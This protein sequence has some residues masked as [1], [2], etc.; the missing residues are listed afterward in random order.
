MNRL[1]FVFAMSLAPTFQGCDG[2]SYPLGR[3]VTPAGAGNGG[4]AG[5]AAAGTGSGGADGG[6]GGG[7]AS[8]AGAG[9]D[10]GAS[11]TDPSTDCGDGAL[12]ASE[13]CDDN[14]FVPGDGCAACK[15]EPGF[16][17]R[18]EPS[19]CVD[20][21]ECALGTDDCVDTAPCKN[22]VGSFDCECDPEYTWNGRTCVPAVRLVT[23]A[24]AHTCVLSTMGAVRCWGWGTF[25]LPGYGNTNTIGDDETPDSVGDVDLGSTTDQLVAAGSHT[26]A[27]STTGALRCW[28][29]G[30]F[31]KLGYGNTSDIGDDEAPRSAGEVDVGGPVQQVAI[32]FDHTC[33]L[34]TSGAVRCWGRGRFGQLG[35]GN[36]NDVGDDESPASA[37]D[38][39]VGGPVKQ[40][41]A[42]GYHTCALLASGGVRCWGMGEWGELGYGNN[43]D[44]FPDTTE[45]VNIV[46][47]NET[48]ASMGDVDVGG[49]VQQIVA[50]GHRTCALLTSGAVRCWGAGDGGALGYGNT[51]TIGDDETPASAGDVDVGG[52]VRQLSV[53]NGVVCALL[54]TG[55]LRCWGYVWTG[56]G[57]LGYGNM[58]SIGD[59]ETPASAGDLHI[60]GPVRQISAG[61]LH[62]C[63]LLARGSV[64]C[65]GYAGQ[66]ALGYGNL[67][68]IGD[69]EFPASAGN[70]AVF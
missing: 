37:G 38:V 10:A 47:N 67:E 50:G 7:A 25:G 59:D 49:E 53:G 6:G 21:D 30:A 60:G 29:S 54:V 41:A 36:E 14:N 24:D 8:A 56:G 44:F 13:A 23:A 39:D 12:Q 35:Y 69:D 18:A 33:A 3:P 16:L 31:G 9:G 66:G 43:V 11:V 4:G 48:P 52:P 20:I 28:G 32:G 55:G 2:R 42:S 57:S 19:V 15:I 27:I 51:D 34:L 40:I 65:W 62:H 61:A 68:N 22:T 45:D 58:E 70:V 1:A 26:C 63:A 64:R 46:G 5:D 17:C